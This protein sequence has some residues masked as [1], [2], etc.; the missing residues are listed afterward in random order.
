MKAEVFFTLNIFFAR[1]KEDIVY[2]D[3]TG[4]NIR[5]QKGQTTPFYIYEL[6]VRHPKKGCSPLPVATYVTSDHTTT[7]VSHFL[8][9]FVTDL[10]KQHGR[11]PRSRPVMLICDGSVVL[12]QSLSMHFC[13]ISLQELLTR[14]YCV[15]TG[16]A[17]DCAIALPILHRC[18]RH[19]MKNAKDL[20]KKQ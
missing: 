11:Q 18:L 15:V 20:C 5:K 7:S 3:A 6:L 2:L 9:S 17:K 10:M 13:G 8:G 19:V 16:Q 1:C 4:S 14:Y 12:M